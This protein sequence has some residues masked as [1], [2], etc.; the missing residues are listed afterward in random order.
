MSVK[1]N[2]TDQ[3]VQIT[4]RDTDGNVTDELSYE[5]PDG[6]PVTGSKGQLLAHNGVEWMQLGTGTSGYV[7]SANPAA[8]L[9]VEWIANTSG[10]SLPAGITDLGFENVTGGEAISQYMLVKLSSDGKFYTWQYTD[11]P[12]LVYGVA[13]TACAGNGSTFYVGIGSI[14]TSVKSDGTTTI[15]PGDRIEPSTSQHGR[16]RKGETN[17]IGISKS[18]VAASLDAVC[19]VKL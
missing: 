14:V 5:P 19:T 13:A 8:S 15:A 18:T 4:K 7:L 16:V 2:I 17:P 1:V 11:D 9:G 10:L 6:L 3:T 12:Y